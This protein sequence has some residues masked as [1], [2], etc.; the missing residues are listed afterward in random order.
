MQ[1]CVLVNRN[2]LVS[3]KLYITVW[4]SAYMNKFVIFVMNNIS[5]IISFWHTSSDHCCVLIVGLYFVRWIKFNHFIVKPECC[6]NN[7]FC[8]Q[9]ICMLI[10][11]YW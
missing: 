5:L 10:A 4:F 2:R 9:F 3:G 8:L 11:N 6:L 1:F 7:A